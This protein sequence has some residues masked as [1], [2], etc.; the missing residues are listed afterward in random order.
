MGR[1]ASRV[2][3]DRENERER[4]ERRKGEA[5]SA[6]VLQVRPS[7]LYLVRPRERAPTHLFVSN[8]L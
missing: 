2:P 6:N 4:S 5:E 8:D 1:S 3:L 7:Y